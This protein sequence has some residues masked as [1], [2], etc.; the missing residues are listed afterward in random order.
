[1]VWLQVTILLADLHGYLDNMKAPWE[2][3]AYRTQYYEAIIKAMLKAIKVPIEKLSFVRG[4]DY[5][6]S[7]LVDMYLLIAW[8]NGTATKMGGRRLNMFQLFEMTT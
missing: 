2:L 7:R 8:I 6:L 5:Q 4:T 3:L 1:M